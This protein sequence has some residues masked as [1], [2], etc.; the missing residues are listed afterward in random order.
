MLNAGDRGELCAALRLLDTRAMHT[1]L[2]HQ[3]DRGW[4]A[5]G[6]RDALVFPPSLWALVAYQRTCGALSSPAGGGRPSRGASALAAAI[7]AANQ[8]VPIKGRMPMPIGY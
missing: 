6:G 2:V 8:H 5:L 7:T 4:L 1:R 3:C